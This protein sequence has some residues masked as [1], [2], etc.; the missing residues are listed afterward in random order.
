MEISDIRRRLRQ[1][2]ETA[3]RRATE[4]RVRV[5]AASRAWEPFLVNKATP[6]LRMFA[7]ALKAE[8]HPFQVFTPAGGLRLMSERSSD[9][10]IELALDT[11]ADPPAVVGRVNRGRGSRLITT[12]RAIRAD[13]PVESL[14]EEDVLAFL[15]DEIAAFLER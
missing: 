9:D 11:A 12:E 7:N 14:T 2:I 15:L 10:F 1:T 6:V 8:G 5:D 3:R 4:R 13:T